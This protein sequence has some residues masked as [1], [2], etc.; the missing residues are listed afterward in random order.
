MDRSVGRGALLP[1]SRRQVDKRPADVHLQSGGSG[2]VAKNTR[3]R[4]SHQCSCGSPSRSV[5]TKNVAGTLA[6]SR[7]GA[8][9]FNA[10]RSPSSSVTA[11]ERSRTTPSRIA[12]TRSMRLTGS[13]L[14]A[15]NLHLGAKI[16]GAEREVVAVWY[17]DPMR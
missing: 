17:R 14:V 7:I 9:T 15:E 2:I 5:V 1:R 3:S 6:A 4:T 8:A 13:Y 16:V 11:T 10:L 12:P